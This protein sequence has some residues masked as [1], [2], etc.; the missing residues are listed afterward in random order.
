MAMPRKLSVCLLLAGLWFRAP[1]QEARLRR[2][3]DPDASRFQ[4]L[5]SKDDEWWIERS[6]DLRQW[7]RESAMP[8]LAS[9]PGDAGPIREVSAPAGPV[10]FHRAVRTGGLYDDTLL[11]RLHLRFE[12]PDW[13]DLLIAAHGTSSNVLCR[14]EVDNGTVL[15]GVGARYKGNSSFSPLL[16]RKSLNLLINHIRDADEL[17]GYEAFNLNNAQGDGT[18]LREAIF[19][20][21]MHRYA[22]GPRGALAT[23]FINDEY[24]GVY[25][26]A[27]QEDGDLIREWF[28]SNE[29]DRWRA[30]NKNPGGSALTW[31]G[32][33][34]AAYHPFYELKKSPDAGRA[35][36]RLVHAVDVLS[37]TPDSTRR[38]ALEDVFGVD[39]WLWLLAV[40][41][42]FSEDDS[43]MNK[44]ADYGFYFE[45]E[46]GRIFP[47]EHDGNEG[48]RPGVEE[49]S[50]VEGAE[51]EGRPMI[52]RLLV[53]PELR[54][55][56][57]AHVR[58]VL[59]ESFN[60]EVLTPLIDRMSALSA[61]AIAADPRMEFPDSS[62]ADEVRILKSFVT[63]RH[64]FLIRHPEVAT[65]PPVIGP[66]SE[67]EP[68]S[69]G[70]SVTLAAVVKGADGEGIGQVSLWYRPGQ[71]G[72]YTR[73]A[74]RDDGVGPDESARD[75]RWAARIPPQLAG[76]T[77]S[78]YI[79]ART[80][81]K[82]G[83][84][85]YFPPR[86]ESG[87]LVCRVT[88][89]T[90][91]NSSVVISEF[92]A[93]NSGSVR[94]PQGDADDWIELQNRGGEAADLSG[95]YLSDDPESPRKWRVPSGTVI[96]AGGY[97]MVWAD[98]D[99]ADL[100]GL[101]ANFRLSA[102]GETLM[103]VDADSRWNVI[104]DSVTYGR[105]SSDVA[106]GRTA[107]LP[108]AFLPVPPTPGAAN[109]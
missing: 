6:P 21:V 84:A 63:N 19:F 83:I 53:L 44:G 27:Q 2:V 51:N 18:I 8:P 85:A 40:E 52:S 11:R 36:G 65:Y 64:A 71:A 5:G 35:W 13:Q 24:W 88:Q 7:S 62:Y 14:L 74:M 61:D 42:V 43:Y 67:P 34:P 99:V 90:P 108:T 103:L 28:P 60:P 100:P 101:H 17:L 58:T 102:Q 3:V 29:G 56:Y 94:D 30:P 45:P 48:F 33:D 15:T 98:E 69:P 89:G 92:M 79:E 39:S 57:L 46:S 104:R 75:G 1:G 70:E 96:R 72:K 55:R 41:N 91:G 105:V 97:L 38:E 109:P 37:N 82:A 78:Y 80:A 23:L 77:L 81:D 86:A 50:P 66:V 76:T 59:A 95:W 32:A 20:N 54:Q 68:P 93:A 107:A 73:I 4:I 12:Q 25:S 31:L 26:L 47:L 106:L 49:V 22:P 9:G 10:A 87:P 16:P